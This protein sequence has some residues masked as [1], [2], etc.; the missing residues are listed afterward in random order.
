VNTP[1][2]YEEDSWFNIQWK[3][4]LFGLVLFVPSC[5]GVVLPLCS[6][7]RFP[8]RGHKCAHPLETL[9]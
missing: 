7:P 8:T 5:I 2:S 6:R 9:S 1:R 4:F 3:L